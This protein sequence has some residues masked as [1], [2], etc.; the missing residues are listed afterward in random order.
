MD[1]MNKIQYL[2]I[3]IKNNLVPLL[4]CALF[5]SY[6]IVMFAYNM[7]RTAA[8]Q[9]YLSIVYVWAGYGRYLFILVLLSGFFRE[10]D[11]CWFWMVVLGAEYILQLLLTFIFCTRFTNASMTL[12]VD[13]AGYFFIY[14]TCPAVIA[15]LIGRISRAVRND[16]LSVALL[17]ILGSI[18][19]FNIV[20]EILAFPVF[21]L[22]EYVYTIISKTFV[23]FNNSLRNTF[24]APNI[25]APFAVG[26]TD[27]GTV[28]LWI[29]LFIFILGM[30]RKKKAAFVMAVL[31]MGAFVLTTLPENK[32]ETYFNQSAF[33]H[34]SKMLDSWNDERIYYDK[35]GNIE[36]T[37]IALEYKNPFE[38][39]SAEADFTIE[40]YQLDITVGRSTK[41]KAVLQLSGAGVREYMFSLY[42]GYQVHGITDKEGGALAFEQNDD[43][44]TIFSNGKA[45]EEITVTYEGTGRTYM[46]SD[47]YT[48]L[49]EYY[50]YYPVAGK[51]NLYD[52]G[53]QNYSR[54]ISLPETKFSI[55]V[56]ADY[57]VYSNLPSNGDNMF[58][59]TGTGA[60]LIGGKYVK[61]CE[62]DGTMVVYPALK[63]DAQCAKEQYTN[64]VDAFQKQGVVLDKKT[65]FVCPYYGGNFGRYYLGD[66]YMFGSYDELMVNAEAL[67]YYGKMY[68]IF[69]N[70]EEIQ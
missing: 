44:L 19:L 39:V 46:A 53:T 28:V 2:R 23:I 67:V 64:I 60:S 29:S 50:I 54:D 56:H 17:L 24:A 10:K 9:D 26:V 70:E 25:F 22:S 66:G 16:I 5:F 38:P 49:P 45:L 6:I 48:C 57:P 69:F 61:A 51:Y 32:Y 18:Y 4:F 8:V 42:H 14:V 59:G 21:H 36:N 12:F 63:A 13:L 1:S 65:W 31:V 37:N 52:F 7:L 47:V 33:A 62:V 34:K 3:K 30:M 43:Y 68:G 35:S 40:A 27:V 41:F 55:T 11:D 20:Q 58:S 15:W